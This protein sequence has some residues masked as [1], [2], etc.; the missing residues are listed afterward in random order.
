M[1][2]LSVVSKIFNG[3]K[4]IERLHPTICKM[5]LLAETRCITICP[6]LM[7]SCEST[8][9]WSSVT[10]C[11]EDIRSM[12]C[13]KKNGTLKYSVQ[14]C[15]KNWEKLRI[16]RIIAESLSQNNEPQEI[17]KRQCVSSFVPGPSLLPFE[18]ICLRIYLWCTVRWI[19]KFFS[20]LRN[21]AWN[22]RALRWRMRSWLKNERPCR[23]INCS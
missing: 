6:I 15:D 9:I 4:K 18:K 23:M 7:A 20:K 2:W 12:N 13:K 19:R 22:T 16:F 17:R 11:F 8:Q 10:L 5:N 21:S 14:I 3:R 1:S